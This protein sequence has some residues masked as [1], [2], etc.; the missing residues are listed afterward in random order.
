M[1]QCNR[2]FN[3]FDSNQRCPRILF[4]C[5][6]TIWEQCLSDLLEKV[7]QETDHEDESTTKVF[8]CPECSTMHSFLPINRFPKNLALLNIKKDRSLDKNN[9]SQDKNGSSSYKNLTPDK[10]IHTQEESVPC[11]F[12]TK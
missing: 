5:G 9:E 12:H 1:I 8:Y 10:S 7:T 2:W 11:S 4:E 3:D 6:H